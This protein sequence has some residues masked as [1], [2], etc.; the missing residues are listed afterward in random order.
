ML[1]FYFQK[2]CNF[3]QFSAFESEKYVD[4]FHNFFLNREKLDFSGR[5]FT[6]GHALTAMCEPMRPLNTLIA[7]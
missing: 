4:I 1:I 2:K 7:Y 6:Y 5:I 3:G